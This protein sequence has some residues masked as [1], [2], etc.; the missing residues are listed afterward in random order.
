MKPIFAFFWLIVMLCFAALSRMIIH[1]RFSTNANDQEIRD[2][3]F[4]NSAFL[5]WNNHALLIL[6]LVMLFAI[7][8]AVWM[9]RN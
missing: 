7:S 5:S 9:T 6:G 1:Y 2:A 3:L 8:F 4:N